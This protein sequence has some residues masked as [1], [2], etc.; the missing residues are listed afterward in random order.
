MA[1]QKPTHD[2]FTIIEKDG[3]QKNYWLRIGAAWTNQDGSLNVTLNAL[4][5]GTQIQIRE[6][7]AEDDDKS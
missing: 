7:R 2:V 3:D 1:N 6:V 4:P 5:I